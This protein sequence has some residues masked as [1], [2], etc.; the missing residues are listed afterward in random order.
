MFSTQQLK[1]IQQVQRTMLSVDHMN[2][3][4]DWL[5]DLLSPL[6][7]LTGTEAI[8]L[9]EPKQMQEAFP[10]GKK[11]LSVKSP[12]L[13]SQFCDCVRDNFMG[14]DQQGY[15]LFEDDYITKQH[16]LVR[17]FGQKAVHDALVYDL[18]KWREC[19]MYGEGYQLVDIERQMALSV[20]L[21]QGESLL[22]FGYN[23]DNI[24][25]LGAECHQLLDLILPAYEAN[26]R[27]R[28]RLAGQFA[29][30][31]N[32]I[33]QTGDALIAFSIDG[34]EH[35]R[36]AALKKLLITE[37]KSEALLAAIQLFAVQPSAD[38][39]SPSSPVGRASCTVTLAYQ[40]YRLRRYLD[41]SS[42]PV[43][44]LMIAVERNSI[45]PASERWQSV[46]NL[47]SREAEVVELL[48]Q[49]LTD[50]EVAERL[51][52]SVHT[53]HRH[54]ERILKKLNISSRAGIAHALW[55]VGA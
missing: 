2:P 40:S 36:N 24:P 31:I 16:Q 47:T 41:C 52:I 23:E 8:F 46:F 6:A 26:V 21:P 30:W 39:T 43:P 33:D 11:Q 37:P 29:D 48:T 5:A 9:V 20:P 18:S 45:L 32:R 51:F 3:T 12:T 53:A 54:S 15:S 7:S 49:G 42:L 1:L 19:R 17:Y 4:G 13:D 34:K 35:Y 25:E 22:V 55:S 38:T 27:F 50:R 28:Q 14:H 44:T 10:S